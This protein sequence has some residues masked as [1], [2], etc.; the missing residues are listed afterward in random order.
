MIIRPYT[1]NLIEEYKARV[2]VMYA[3]TQGK[4]IQT[5]ARTGPGS[6]AWIH[7]S[8]PQW[9]WESCEYRVKP[10]PR[11]EDLRIYE[12]NGKRFTSCLPPCN[13]PEPWRY[14]RTIT[15]NLEDEE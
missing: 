1:V 13:V 11:T 2:E 6:D 14:V 5:R 7:C 4:A 10:E 9:M 8:L 12:Y 3:E 15:V